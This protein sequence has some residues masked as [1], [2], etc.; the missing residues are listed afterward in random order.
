MRWGNLRRCL[1]DI[2][3]ADRGSHASA[4]PNEIAPSDREFSPTRFC[5][6][7]GHPPQRFGIHISYFR[8]EQWVLYYNIARIAGYGAR[9]LTL[10][11]IQSYTHAMA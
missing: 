2:Q 9:R 11:A 8:P 1:H 10:S 7:H 5:I 3:H 4:N 6:F